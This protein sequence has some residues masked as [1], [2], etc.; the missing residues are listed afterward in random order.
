MERFE[1][2][3]TYRVN[4]GGK[5]TI[6]KRTKYFITFK[7]DFEGKKKI[8]DFG[9]KGLFGLGENILIPTKCPAIKYFCFAGHVE[10]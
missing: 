5:I 9:D 4:G 1:E 6:T 10:Q 8:H 2:G 3:K 7:G